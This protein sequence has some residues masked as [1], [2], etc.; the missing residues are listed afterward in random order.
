MQ[1]AHLIRTALIAFALAGSGAAAAAA[2]PGPAVGQTQV[3][4]GEQV[5][6]RTRAGHDYVL[7]VTATDEQGFVG[8][9][10][11]GKRWRV[12]Y[13]QID[14]LER[15]ERIERIGTAPRTVSAAPVQP[16]FWLS[17]G[18]G[19][20]EGQDYDPPPGRQKTRAQEVGGGEVMLAL[21]LAGPVLARLRVA[22]LVDFTSNTAEDVGALV[23]LPLDA[24]RRV[25]LATGV[26]RLTDVSN[27]RQSPT[28]GVPVELLFYPWRGLEL[29][30]HGNF[31]PDSDFVGVTAAGVFG[32]QRDR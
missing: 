16:D 14:R 20:Y 9:D 23:G 13:G 25:F 30:L 31:N 6:L 26:S 10:A 12:P 24:E 28:I 27:T 3:R 2:D 17:F 8:R 11:G 29:G 21:N 22:Y 4:E 1:A 18:V 7:T 5:R 15:V 32:K 19:G